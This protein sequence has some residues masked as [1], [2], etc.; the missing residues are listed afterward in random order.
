MLQITLNCYNRFEFCKP[1]DVWCI[2]LN[3]QH[4]TACNRHMAK[5]Y[6]C[7]PVCTHVHG[8]QGMKTLTGGK[9]SRTNHIITWLKVNF[10][11]KFVAMDF[12]IKHSGINVFTKM[13]N[14]VPV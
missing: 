14:E 8:S 10:I 5:P 9:H 6:I 1:Y 3:R 4:C 2:L 12:L 7:S 11:F 13:Q